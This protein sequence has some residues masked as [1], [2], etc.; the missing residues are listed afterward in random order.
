MVYGLGT[1]SYNASGERK[2]NK[3]AQAE[4]TKKWEAAPHMEVVVGPICTCRS[5]NRPHELRRHR[6]LRS[7]MDWRT[8][9]ERGGVFYDRERVK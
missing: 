4:A 3:L 5:F 9:R 1:R 7:E 2:Q 8:E 6:E